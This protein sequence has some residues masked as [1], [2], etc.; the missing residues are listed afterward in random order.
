MSEIRTL[1][2][3]DE[4]SGLRLDAFISKADDTISRNF[5]QILI[6]QG[7]V[8]VNGT[9]ELSKKKKIF[10]G[11]TVTLELPDPEPLE[12]EPQ[13]IPIEIVYEDQDLIVV[14][15]PQGCLLYTSPSPRDRG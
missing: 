2:A 7:A 6:S 9:P 15:K 13:N 10:T 3:S 8:T 12:A 11:D 4:N 14:N 1:K 5:A